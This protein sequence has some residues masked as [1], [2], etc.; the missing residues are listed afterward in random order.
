MTLK[1]QGRVLPV[2]ILTCSGAT[3]L[4]EKVRSSVM[5]RFVNPIFALNVL[6][7]VGITIGQ[8]NVSE[9]SPAVREKTAGNR[10]WVEAMRKAH[11]R[12]TRK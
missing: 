12:S 11:R 8:S 1:G 9:W 3:N 7:D 4:L 2:Q 5:R 6:R 10:G